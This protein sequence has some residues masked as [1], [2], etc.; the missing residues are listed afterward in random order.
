MELVATASDSRTTGARFWRNRAQ[1]GT[2][3]PPLQKDVFF[4]YTFELP[5]NNRKH[6]PIASMTVK[7]QS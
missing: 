6:R 7:E 5:E 1:C 2:R 4:Q 3:T